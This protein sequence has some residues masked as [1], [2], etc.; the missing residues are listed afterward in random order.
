MSYH[1]PDFEI[2]LDADTV[3]TRIIGRVGRGKKVLELGCSS[4][5]MSRVLVERFECRVTGV[6]RDRAAAERA[7]KVCDR[8][9]LADLER[10]DFAAELGS[11]RFDVVVCADVLEHL[12][13]PVAVLSAVRPLLSDQGYLVASIPNVAHASIIAE[14]IEGRFDYRPEG[15]LDET[16]LRFFTLASIHDCFERGGFAVTGLDRIRV[17]PELTE[18]RTEVSALPDELL[19]AIRSHPEST[20]YQFVLSAHPTDASSR[21]GAAI[22]EA[23]G[24]HLRPPAGKRGA[25]R[26]ELGSL[27]EALT[28]RMQFLE[29]RRLGL[30]REVGKLREDGLHRESRI[31][32]LEQEAHRQT[33]IIQDQQRELVRLQETFLGKES[34]LLRRLWRKLRHRSNGPAGE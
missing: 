27:L 1:D 25:E 30:T 22:A 26:S 18:F 21:P 10:L 20:T 33:S 14:L 16:H 15:L 7:G 4:G 6:E 24:V 23:A 34:S 19:R 5:Y 17:E 28:S 31:H 8:V 3:H 11:E 32:Q 29:D 9:L 13:D 12:R 2:D